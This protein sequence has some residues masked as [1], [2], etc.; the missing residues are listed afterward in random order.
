[1]NSSIIIIANISCGTCIQ[2]SLYSVRCEIK[3]AH[4]HVSK[5]IKWPYNEYVHCVFMWYSIEKWK[6]KTT[7]TEE[8]RRKVR[9]SLDGHKKTYIFSESN[10]FI[11]ISWIKWIEGKNHK[12]LYRKM[13]RDKCKFPM[14][15][16]QNDTF[17]NQQLLCARL[18]KL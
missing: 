4:T 1:M 11:V 10:Y 5:Q 3:W 13:E 6:K 17:N 18:K 8:W 14:S 7:T 15:P 2:I 9:T 12:M 16:L